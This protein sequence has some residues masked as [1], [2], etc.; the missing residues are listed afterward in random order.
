M[1]A[2]TTPVPTPGPLLEPRMAQLE[3]LEAKVSCDGKNNRTVSGLLSKYQTL[4]SALQ[5]CL[6]QESRVLDIGLCQNHKFELLFYQTYRVF[7]YYLHG[8][9]DNSEMTQQPA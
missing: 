3:T 9:T 1:S 6:S 2:S 5:E 4:I 7:L 8:V